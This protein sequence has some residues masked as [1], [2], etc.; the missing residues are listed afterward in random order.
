MERK[1]INIKRVNLLFNYIYLTNPR[2]IIL[3]LKEKK[4]PIDEKILNTD[5][6]FNKYYK[7]I[8]SYFFDWFSNNLDDSKEIKNL[9]INYHPDSKLFKDIYCNFKNIEGNEMDDEDSNDNNNNKRK[10][11]EVI[12][13]V[14]DVQNVSLSNNKSENKFEN[15]NKYMPLLTFSFYSLTIITLTINLLHIYKSK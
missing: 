6:Y 15:L 1:N 9:L 10:S 7:S 4:Y 12:T 11:D 2:Y 3:F 8:K 13:Q 14:K 5:N